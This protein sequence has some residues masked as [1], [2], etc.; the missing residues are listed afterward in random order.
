MSSIKDRSKFLSLVLRHQPD[1]IKLQLDLQGWVGVTTLL[2]NLKQYGPGYLQPFDFEML[3]QV[4]AE[5]DKKRFAFNADKTMIRASQGHSVDIK[6]GYDPVQPPEFLYHGT[7]KKSVESILKQGI[8]KGKR[9]HVHLSLQQA[10]A[11]N[12]GGRHGAPVVLTVRAGEMQRAG[13]EFY[14]SENG[15]W[16]TDLVPSAYILVP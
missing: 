11:V 3:E 9:H 16:L 14:C 6:L 4:V 5:N 7:A 8:L 15:V 12:V 2:D 10:T 13:F 1:K